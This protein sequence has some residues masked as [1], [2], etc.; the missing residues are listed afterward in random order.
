M[1]RI[2]LPNRLKSSNG[3]I[4]INGESQSGSRSSSPMRA[5]ADGKALVLKTTVLRVGRV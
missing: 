3:K 5:S 2:P 1:V 4:G